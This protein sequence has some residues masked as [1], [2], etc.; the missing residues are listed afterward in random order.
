M[1]LK[2][3]FNK[4]RLSRSVAQKVE[5]II[6]DRLLD[7]AAEAQKTSPVGATG[8]LVQGW[9]ITP[10]TTTGRVIR[11]VVVNN[12]QNSYYR[13]VGRGPGKQP[14]FTP[15]QA[16]VIFKNP[17]LALNAVWIRTQRLRESIA[18]RGT[19]RWRTENNPI[20]LRPGN[21]GGGIIPGGLIDRIMKAI[22]EDLRKL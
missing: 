9:D 16:W 7:F 13:E 3:K 22:L 10:A 20:G 21:K 8:G 11:G 5:R 17:G 14:P 4:T 2:I 15:I 1:T 19:E 12:A 6:D 18:E